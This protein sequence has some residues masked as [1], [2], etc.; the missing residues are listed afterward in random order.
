MDNL[1]AE[2]TSTEH[3]HNCK[4][5]NPNSLIRNN[6]ITCR[7]TCQTSVAIIMH[8]WTFFMALLIFLHF[9]HDMPNYNFWNSQ[10][11]RTWIHQPFKTGQIA[12]YSFC[13]MRMLL[14][15]W[16]FVSSFKS[17]WVLSCTRM[18]KCQ[19]RCL[20]PFAKCLNTLGKTHY[21]SKDVF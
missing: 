2:N 4:I 3:H 1:I 18:T 20:P 11:H 15:S 16:R 8:N 7:T 21:V 14:Q 6:L 17:I 13:K 19:T 10:V 9:L 5:N 12:H